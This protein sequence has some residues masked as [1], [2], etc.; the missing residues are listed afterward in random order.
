MIKRRIMM[1]KR[2]IVFSTVAIVFNYVVTF[3]FIVDAL[4]RAQE[5]FHQTYELKSGS[6]LS[7]ENTNGSISVTLWDK[8]YVD[9]Y[10]VKK[11]TKDEDELKKVEIQV[12]KNDELR[13]KTHYIKKR[14]KVS[15]DYTIK[16]PK[17]I[18]VER[19]KTT[20]GQ[21]ELKGTYGD[22]YVKSTNGTLRIK[23]TDGF[24]EA[25]TTN[26]D[27]NLTGATGIKS[28]RT[29]N[30]SINVSFSKL[31][32]SV[33]ITTTNGSINLSIPEDLDADID[34]STTN[35]SVKAS[36]IRIMLDEISKHHITGKLGSGG[37]RLK[38]KTV[39]GAIT[40]NKL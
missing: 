34:L 26:G 27:I 3:G 4:A 6:P 37:K 12:S 36:G 15:V 1:H 23:D 18:R 28:A 24:I 11:T 33:E 19:T 31:A 5:E 22:T 16:V 2:M 17:T 7:V 38:A 40:I 35:G 14:A 39:N 8:D 20:N 21:V 9:V 10:A 32:A 13:I 29:T 25:Y 30:G